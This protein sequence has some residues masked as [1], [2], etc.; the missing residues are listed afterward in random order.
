MAG[1]H[2]HAYKSLYLHY[3][4]STKVSSKLKSVDE[5]EDS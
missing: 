5:N 3:G 2:K 4:S 1:W